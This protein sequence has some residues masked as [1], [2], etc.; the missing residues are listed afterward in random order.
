MGLI[1]ADLELISA[2]D[3]ALE[4]KGYIQKNQ[5]KKEKVTALVDSGAY[6]MCINEHIKNQLDLMFIETKEAEMA[7]GTITRIDV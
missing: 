7:N 1:Y 6:M 2:E 4:R 5:I 3:V